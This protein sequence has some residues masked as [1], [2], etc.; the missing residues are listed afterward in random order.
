MIRE[1]WCH[2]ELRNYWPLFPSIVQK[3]SSDTCYNKSVWCHLRSF[4]KR[5]YRQP[6]L[7][8]EWCKLTWSFKSN[9]NIEQ[10]SCSRLVVFKCVLV[11]SSEVRLITTKQKRFVK[12]TSELGYKKL[13][14]HHTRTSG[15][16][17]HPNINQTIWN[18]HYFVQFWNGSLVKTVLYIKQSYKKYFI[19]LYKY[20]DDFGYWMLNL[21]LN[22]ILI[23]R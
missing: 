12:M 15:Q 9:M 21:C 1:H 22:Q 7:F 16:T 5:V 13:S 3:L 2:F 20:P 4:S 8:W 10:R 17:G 18:P 19:L 11:H 23:T 6:D 14:T